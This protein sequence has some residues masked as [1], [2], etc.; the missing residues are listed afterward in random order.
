MLNVF[1]CEDNNV[2]RNKFT[3]IIENYIIIENLDMEITLSTE[4]PYAILNYL[5]NNEISGLYFLD[6]DL[7]TDID[8][9]LLAEKIREYDTSGFIVFITTYGEMSPLTFK[10]KIE[11]MDFIIKNEAFDIAD[12]IYQCIIAANKKYCSKTAKLKQKFNIKINDKIINIDYNK[13]LF[14]ETSETKHK[15]ILHALNKQVEFKSQVKVVEDKLDTNTFYRCHKSYIV[16]KNNIKEIDILK[17]IVCMINGE[18]CPI[19]FRSINELKK[20]LKKG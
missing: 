20:Q 6:I 16:N 10:Y 12:R 19:S 7:N 15:L 3:K 13:I 9:L 18:E 11:A 17:R 4:N 5:N 2:L 8:G 14:F 1:V